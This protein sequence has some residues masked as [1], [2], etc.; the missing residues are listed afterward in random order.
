M[1]A[2]LIVLGLL[3]LALGASLAYVLSE[4]RRAPR[5]PVTLPIA[6]SSVARSS[7]AR[8]L[9]EATARQTAEAVLAIEEGADERARDVLLGAMER[10]VATVVAQSTTV[11]VALTSDDLKGRIIGREGRNLAALERAT[12]VDVLIADDAPTVTLSSL[13]PLRREV[14]RRALV[15][16]LSEGRMQPARIE[17]VV[18]AER[19]AMEESLP[20]LGAEAAK[21]AGVDPKPKPVMAAMGVLA[22][23]SSASQNVLEHSVQCA[24]LAATI[25]GQ[26]GVA[27]QLAARAAFLHDIGKGLEPEWGAAHAEAGAAFLKAHNEP[28]TVCEAVRAHH[29]E[30][31]PDALSAVVRVADAVSGSRPG[32]RRGDAEAF[33]QRV[34]ALEA[35]A[36]SEPGVADAYAVHAGR[37]LRVVVQSDAVDDMGARELSVRIAEAIAQHPE[38]RGRVLVTVIRETRHEAWTPPQVP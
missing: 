30:R 12:G 21:R 32:A 15:S 34:Q 29:D 24:E 11:T 20:G 17:A 6:P 33:L 4:L 25:A 1:V 27:P 7:D 5:G 26:L 19:E 16:L 8:G 13:D 28:E 9:I 18:A 31:A 36:R 2:S 37:E 35:I 38:T 22:F 14:A 10:C 23:R 3:V